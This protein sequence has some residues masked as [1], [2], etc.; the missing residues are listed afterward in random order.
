M[1]TAHLVSGGDDDPSA[2][3]P[4][5]SAPDSLLVGVELPP[6]PYRQACGPAR[7]AVPADSWSARVPDGDD[8]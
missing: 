3:L 7:P 6:E 8:L 5:A 2:F 1:Q 4:R